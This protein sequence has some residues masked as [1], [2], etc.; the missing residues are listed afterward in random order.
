VAAAM[1]ESTTTRQPSDEEWVTV[2]PPPLREHQRRRIMCNYNRQSKTKPF[3]FNELLLEKGRLPQG[4]II[5]KQKAE[6]TLG[7]METELLFLKY[8]F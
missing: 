8:F 1:Q 2:K 7:P 3:S 5:M 4:G 6:R